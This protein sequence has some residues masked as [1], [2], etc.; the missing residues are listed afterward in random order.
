MPTKIDWMNGWTTSD[1]QP[2]T[3]ENWH[4]FVGCTPASRGCENCWARRQEES[5]G[6]RGLAR[7]NRLHGRRFWDRA[8]YQGDAVLT[9]PLHWRKPR[10]VFVCPSS[11]WCH[12]DISDAERDKMLAV[13]T[14]RPQHIFLFLTKQAKR[15]AEWAMQPFG[16]FEYG[17]W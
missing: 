17:Q 13:A 16:E 12:E 4:V 5:T 1:G 8:V 15:L 3:G 7:L 6:P 14:L 2:M 10:V 11:D 9:K